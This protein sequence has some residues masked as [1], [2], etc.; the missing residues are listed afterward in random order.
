MPITV[1]Y[2]MLTG[3]ITDPT[4]GAIPLKGF[5]VT[6][7][8]GTFDIEVTPVH[9]RSAE[10]GVDFELIGTNHNVLSYN[11]EESA[12]KKVRQQNIDEHGM[13]ITG[14]ELRVTYNRE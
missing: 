10:L 13:G 1:E 7:P 9:G 2:L 12:I 4:D 8:L 11:L 5:P 14:P 3:P 6:G